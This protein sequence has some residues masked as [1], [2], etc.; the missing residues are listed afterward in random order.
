MPQVVLA[1]GAKT[2]ECIKTPA[3]ASLDLAQYDYI[4]I[5]DQRQY[6]HDFTATTTVDW[7]W[8]KESLISSRLASFPDWAVEQSQET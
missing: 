7:A 3:Y 2:V 5:K 6:L 8:V 4:L 1:M